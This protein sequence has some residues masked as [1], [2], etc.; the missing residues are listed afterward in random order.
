M[1]EKIYEM[2]GVWRDRHRPD[3]V[4]GIT[5]R[6]GQNRIHVFIDIQGGIKPYVAIEGDELTKFIP[7]RRFE[8]TT[9]SFRMHYGDY[10]FNDTLFLCTTDWIS[11]NPNKQKGYRIEE[12]TGNERD[13][14]FDIVLD[15][16]RFTFLVH[17]GRI[18]YVFYKGE[19]VLE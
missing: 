16:E 2:M 1:N 9:T 7:I 10:K 12:M 5:L 11:F 18:D 3:T 15:I 4:A 19:C 17:D 14:R 6:F 13:C 8:E